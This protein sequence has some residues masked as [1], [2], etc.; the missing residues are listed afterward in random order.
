MKEMSYQKAIDELEQIV[1]A[2]ETGDIPVDDLAKKVKRASELIKVCKTVLYE[3]SD[4]VNRVLSEMD[5]VRNT[6]NE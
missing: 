2:M 4:E 3:T 5:E 1:A 6:N